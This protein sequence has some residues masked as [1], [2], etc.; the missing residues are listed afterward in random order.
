[1]CLDIVLSNYLNAMSKKLAIDDACPRPGSAFRVGR[2]H[3]D[4]VDRSC[5]CGGVGKGRVVKRCYP[6]TLQ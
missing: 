5:R 3:G 6:V 2:E 4:G 1:M